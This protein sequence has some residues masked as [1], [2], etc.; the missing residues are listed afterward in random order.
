MNE[1]EN[2][3]VIGGCGIMVLFLAVAIIFGIIY[4]ACAMS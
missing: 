2:G 4:I 1:N 3:D